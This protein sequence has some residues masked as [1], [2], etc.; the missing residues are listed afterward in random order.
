MNDK[1]N[2]PSVSRDLPKTVII[3][4]SGFLGNAFLSS[5]RT[6][7]PDSIGTIRHSVKS[8]L[9]NHVRLDLLA[10]NIDKMK[11][12]QKGHRQALI[13]A[14]VSKLM[15]CENNMVNSRQINV[16]GTIELIRQ[17]REEGIRPIFAS[18]DIVF[19][20]EKGGYLEN[21]PPSPLNE[22][23]NQKA[24]IEFRLQEICKDD[25]LVIRLSKAFSLNKGD[26]TLIDEMA[27]RLKHGETLREAFDLIFCP[28]LIT[29]LIQSVAILQTNDTTGI[30]NVCGSEP[31]SRF[32][33]A[34]S[35]A[36]NMNIDPARVAKVSLGELNLGCRRPKD[37][38][39]V[40]IR[41]I[42][43]TG[44]SFTP[45]KACVR[46]IANNWLKT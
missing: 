9:D 33:L 6:V 7:H 27:S 25:Y 14:S 34:V 20:G 13:F 21:D 45:I 18:S 8:D 39:M 38:S 16:T 30:V 15:E 24:E 36:K 40:N 32:D 4:A 44:F 1:Q 10:P 42:A 17:L 26:G 35:V 46:Q 5:Y 28:L 19:D 23:G 29:D 2:I 22:Y 37:I 43:A 11:L 12:Y 41:C 3:G 31:W